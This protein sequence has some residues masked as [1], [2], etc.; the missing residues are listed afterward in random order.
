MVGADE[1]LSVA[2]AGVAMQDVVTEPCGR[3]P[4]VARGRTL[5]GFVIIAAVIDLP[6]CAT[7]NMQHMR[8]AP[9]EP[10]PYTGYMTS[11]PP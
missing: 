2:A 1:T 3:A 5:A 9:P 4:G 10:P 6:C 7:V 8:P 11:L